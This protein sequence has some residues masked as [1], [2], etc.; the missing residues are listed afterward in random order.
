MRRVNHGKWAE[1][2]EDR[3]MAEKTLVYQVCDAE[4][5]VK[6]LRMWTHYE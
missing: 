1:E 4:P 5:T 2:T 6:V 3:E